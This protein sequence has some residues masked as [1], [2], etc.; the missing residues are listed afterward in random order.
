MKLGTSSIVVA[1]FVGPGT[2]LTCILAG[3]EFGYELG[4][5]LVFATIAV[6]VLQSFTA[7]TGILAGKGIGEAV[8][9][10]ATTP[11][12]RIW[13]FG[14]IILGLGIGCAAFESGNLAGASSGLGILFST[15]SRT[16]YLIFTVV[17]AVLAAILLTFKVKK[18]IQVLGVFVAIMGGVFI[19]GLFVVPI[20]WDEALKGLITPVVSFDNTYTVI[21]LVGTTVVTYTLFLHPGACK[22]YWEGVDASIAWRKELLGMALFIPLGGVVSLSILFAGA[23]NIEFMDHPIFDVADFAWVLNDIVGPA[24]KIVFGA[25]LFVAGL[26]SA[27]TAPLAAAIGISGL[28]GKDESSNLFKGIWIA[29]LLVGL[30]FNLTGIS[31]LQ[32]II[33]AQAANGLLLPV[34]SGFILYLTVRQKSLKLPDWYKFTGLAIVLICAVLGART[35][36]WVIAAMFKN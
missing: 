15:G 6:F 28:F 33:A 16:H 19:F 18:V 4:W 25:G 7:G 31:P 1:A 21:A 9:E 8:F 3:L 20:E 36:L 17:V 22:T 27:V 30:F 12:K 26:T 2:V 14:I 5:V 32:I 13:M 35:L 10:V 34:I 11:F 24:A 29:V 23:T